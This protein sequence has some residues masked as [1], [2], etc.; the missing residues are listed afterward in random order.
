MAFDELP[1]DP[2]K[3]LGVL[4]DAKLPEIRSAHRKLVLKCHPDKVQDAAL[5]AI[6]QDEFQK[7]QQAYELLSDDNRRLQYDEQVKL[8]ALRKEMGRGNATPRSNPFEYEVK[9]AEPRA[10]SYTYARPPPRPMAKETTKVYPQQQRP[11]S[12]E[13]V[14]YE[15]VRHPKKSASYESADRDRKSKSRPSE[16]ERARETRRHEDDERAR[17]K[18]EKESKRAAHGEK[19]KRS[20]KEKKRGAEEKHSSRAAYMEDDFDDD[21]RPAR[22]NEK[23]RQERHRMEEEIR[24]RN[25]EARAEREAARKTETI[26]Q[27]P[28][29]PKWDGHKEWAAQY[30]QA[31]RRKAPAAVEDFHPGPPPRAETYGGPEMK[32]NIRYGAAPAAVYPPSDDD[33]PRR[34]SAPRPSRRTSETP[35]TS[36]AK[37]APKSSS[38]E[39]EREKERE[40]D[41]KKAGRSRSRDPHPHIVSP[42]SPPPPPKQKPSLQT[43][44]SA[45]PIITGATPRKEP[46]RSKTQDYPRSKD[47]GIPSLPRAATF[48]SGDRA[49]DRGTQRGSRLKQRVDY[50]S[51][52]DSDSPVYTS[53]RHSHSP[54]PSRRR[55][56]PEP[57]RYIIDNG[58]SVPITCRA[59]H[60]S[61]MRNIDDEVPY[62]PRDRDRSESPHGTARHPRASERPPMPRA[63]S[64]GARQAPVRS[65]SQTYYPTPPVAPEPVNLEA[66][67]KMP[68]RESGHIHSRSGGPAPAGPYFEQVKYASP[69]RAEDV[70]FNEAYRRG[71]D[72]T[73]HPH[74]ARE[75]GYAS[76]PLRGERVYA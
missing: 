56:V 45:P 43:H 71:S 7:V 31:S 35:A 29:T 8:Y 63:G 57:T 62:P 3:L 59:T 55:E 52:S 47:A 15:S 50:S 1:P 68:P 4:K 16:E 44:N 33:T 12:Y 58:R 2:Y 14:A 69:Y 20:D 23:A 46:S 54:P 32:Y 5:K 65:N 70:I 60:R 34:S 48:Q 51:D 74:A 76:P 13:D 38:K 42:P 9:N 27:A 37:D 75:Y 19:K 6:K 67:P 64:G 66:R 41:K 17:A 28:L 24:I 10:T 30:M 26:R 61:D 40:K 25:E 53:K 49:P 22:S 72:P 11:S 39:K 18:W 21:Y 36:R 73:H